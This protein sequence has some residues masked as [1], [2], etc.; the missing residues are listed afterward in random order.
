MAMDLKV[1]SMASRFAA[2][3]ERRQS[4]ISEN[5]ANADTQAYKARDLK[6]FAEVYDASTADR[7]G[8]VARATRPGHA[9]DAVGGAGREFG[10]PIRL[11]RLG[12]SSPNGNTVSLED[13]VT[14]GAE[15]NL[16]HQMAMTILRTS[17]DILKMGIGRR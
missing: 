14:R 11:A 13:Q 10:D 3:A 7:S 8:F 12:A 9:G 17:M 2:H 4:L 5:V 15:A 16:Q 6:P 1:L